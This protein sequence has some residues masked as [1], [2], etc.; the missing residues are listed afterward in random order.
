VITNPESQKDVLRAIFIRKGKET[1]RTKVFENLA[2]EIRTKLLAVAALRT[3]E[4]PIVASVLDQDRWVLI[5][6]TRVVAVER[7]QP[8]SVDLNLLKDA[9]VDLVADA[10]QGNRSK[11]E[12]SYLRLLLEGGKEQLVQVESG[13]SHIGIWNVLKH[14]A[15][16][17]QRGK[18][19]SPAAS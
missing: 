8:T 2:A 14:A 10:R 18:P 5:T 11:S 6:T 12:L 4:L 19:V 7:D 13:V 15:G 9:T 1:D 16:Q 17:N 3:G